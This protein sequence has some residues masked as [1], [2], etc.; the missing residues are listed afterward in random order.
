MTKAMTIPKKIKGMPFSKKGKKTT[1]AKHIA[2]KMAM[3]KDN[4]N[5]HWQKN[6]KLEFE[7]EFLN[8]SLIINAILE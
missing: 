5:K 2:K 1:P 3:A 8:N 6:S 7:D 4:G